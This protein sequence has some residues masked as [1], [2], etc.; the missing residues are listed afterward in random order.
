MFERAAVSRFLEA[1]IE[2]VHRG[3]EIIEED[4][5]D[6]GKSKIASALRELVLQ[7]RAVHEARDIKKHGDAEK[8]FD[9]FEQKS[10]AVGASDGQVAPEEKP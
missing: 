9:S 8:R 2:G 10:R 7:L 6:Q 1:A 3:I 4:E 5:T